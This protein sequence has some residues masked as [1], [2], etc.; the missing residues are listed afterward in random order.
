MRVPPEEYTFHLAV[1]A[2]K[3]ETAA[4]CAGV[5]PAELLEDLRRAVE[6]PEPVGRR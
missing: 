3:V 6:K 5:T 1:L 4:A 2:S